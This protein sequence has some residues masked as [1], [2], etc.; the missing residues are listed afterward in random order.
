MNDCQSECDCG[1]PGGYPHEPDC[2]SLEKC[3]EGRL[4]EGRMCDK[5]AA[6][7]QADHEYLRGAPRHTVFN[8]AQAVEERN[9]ELI[10]AGRGHLVA[11]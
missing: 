10:D 5:H 1:A 2:R 4:S 3:G 7:A 11:P 9:Q 6:E 8:D